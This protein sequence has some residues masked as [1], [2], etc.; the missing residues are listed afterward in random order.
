MAVPALIG[1]PAASSPSS[2]GSGSV[3]P[4]RCPDQSP[5]VG[6]TPLRTR[7]AQCCLSS[8][9]QLASKAAPRSPR[10]QGRENWGKE[11]VC[12]WCP[13]RRLVL[14]RTQPPSAQTADRGGNG[15]ALQSC[16]S[17]D[18]GPRSLPPSFSRPELSWPMSRRHGGL[19][20]GPCWGKASLK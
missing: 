16:V 6:L 5:T 1:G 10:S 4:S 17:I 2:H 7:S 3:L 13:F 11:R 14:V 18:M 20:G 15:S 8:C 19:C 12:R 9:A